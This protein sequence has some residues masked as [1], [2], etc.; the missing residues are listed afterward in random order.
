MSVVLV[1][2][3][4]RA[5]SSARLPE[6]QRGDDEGECDRQSGAREEPDAQG[7]DEVLRF[8]GEGAIGRCQ[9]V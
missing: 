4:G 9:T 6:C 5:L 1:L 3:S 8:F 2:M 7:I